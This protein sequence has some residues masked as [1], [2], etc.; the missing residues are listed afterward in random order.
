MKRQNLDSVFE[1]E[2]KRCRTKTL[3]YTLCAV[4][5]S[6]VAGVY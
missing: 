6:I 5:E 3:V 1:H 4:L 2:G